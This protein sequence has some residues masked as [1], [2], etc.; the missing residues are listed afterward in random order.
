M[1]SL[2]QLNQYAGAVPTRKALPGRPL[3]FVSTVLIVL[4]SIPL[5]APVDALEG[6]VTTRGIIE[7]GLIL[8]GLA[9]MAAYGQAERILS[10]DLKSPTF[11]LVSLFSFWA[12]LSSIWSSNP[13]LTIA[14]S[15]E[16]WF[17]VVA[18]AMLVRLAT[19]TLSSARLETIL[20]LAIVLVTA[21]LLVGN[22]FVWGTPLPDTGDSS[23][24]LHLIDEEP[25]TIRPRLMLLYA[26]P[27]LTGDLLALG[28]ISLFASNLKAFWKAL[29]I[30][31]LF[32]L[33]WLADARGPTGGLIVAVIGMSILKVRRNDVRAIVMLLAI[34]SALAIGLLFQ[35]RLPSA[36]SALITDDVPT[37]NTRTELWKKVI[38]HIGDQPLLG[39]GFHAS[40]YLLVKD[41]KWG[42]HAHNSFLEV[43][44]TT[45]VIGLTML[46]GF[47][48]YLF[49]RIVNTRNVL[50][51]GAT[52]YCLI[53]GMLNPLLFIPGL[54][55]FVITV[56]VLNAGSERSANRAQTIERG[57]LG[58]G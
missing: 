45:G 51:L 54:P 49:K 16:L 29:L 39:T 27:L 11:L 9:L 25:S 31:A 38:T 4:S 58:N 40:R 10:F 17:L 37:L 22:L 56:A 32:A 13:I 35:D 57:R 3:I 53:Q 5:V 26:H 19:Q 15:A 23:L 46:I 20:G 44:L 24:P 47:V 41:F 55:M 30:P 42:G 33:L 14:K 36:V 21:G 43:T 1:Q 28:V 6:G 52:I 8:A 50:L 18:A 34:S 2:S 7:F 48:L 12:V